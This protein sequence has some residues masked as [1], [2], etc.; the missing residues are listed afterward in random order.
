MSDKD[1]AV[2]SYVQRQITNSGY[3]ETIDDKVYT[4]RSPW[5]ER[6]AAEDLNIGNLVLI[7]DWPVYIGSV[8]KRA[9]VDVIFPIAGLQ[10]MGLNTA[11]IE[12]FDDGLEQEIFDFFIPPDALFAGTYIKFSLQGQK[13][14]TS[15]AGEFK[16]YVEDSNQNGRVEVATIP[17]PAGNRRICDEYL[18]KIITG[19]ETH[20][21]AVNCVKVNEEDLTQPYPADVQLPQITEPGVNVRFALTFKS[22]TTGEIFTLK[23][24]SAI[25]FAA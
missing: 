9:A 15:I 10:A 11:D 12:T 22:A 17:M 19:D 1:D 2:A 7:E 18:L 16:L 25:W 5:N 3:D 4:N 8:W 14:T 23:H 13:Q 21:F 20:D 24:A 6:F